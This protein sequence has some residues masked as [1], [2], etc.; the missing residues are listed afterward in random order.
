MDLFDFFKVRATAEEF[1]RSQCVA[2]SMTRRQL[3][4]KLTDHQTLGKQRFKFQNQLANLYFW[5]H[6]NIATKNYF[7]ET[8]I[9]LM[10]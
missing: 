9:R 3:M 10:A 6:T 4:D 1:V 7:N 8:N 5:L 2:D